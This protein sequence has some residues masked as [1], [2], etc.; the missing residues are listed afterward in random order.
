MCKHGLVVNDLKEVRFIKQQIW[1][2][3]CQSMHHPLTH[4]IP[5]LT[6]EL[7]SI[8]SGRFWNLFQTRFKQVDCPYGGDL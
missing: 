4:W 7:K 8:R 6:C 3:Y 1:L 2:R 5:F